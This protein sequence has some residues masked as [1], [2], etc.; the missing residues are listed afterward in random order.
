MPAD[1][2]AHG[3]PGRCLVGVVGHARRRPCRIPSTPFD[4]A[5]AV[6]SLRAQQ[7]K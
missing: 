5:E 2:G 3:A 4:W 6:R 7:C 1:S